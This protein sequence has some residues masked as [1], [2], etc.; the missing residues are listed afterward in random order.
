ME[1]PGTHQHDFSLFY[2][3][4]IYIYIYMYIYICQC[5]SRERIF[6]FTLKTKEKML[7]VHKGCSIMDKGNNISKDAKARQ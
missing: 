1:P 3:V 2:P 4:V 5:Y 6:D 7:S